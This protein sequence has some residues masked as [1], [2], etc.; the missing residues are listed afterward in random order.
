MEER[1]G[2]RSDRKEGGYGERRE[3]ERQLELITRLVERTELWTR[4]EPSEN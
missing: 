2:D 3:R 4:N 1:S